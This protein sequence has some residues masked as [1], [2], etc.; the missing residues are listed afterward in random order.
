MTL[1]NSRRRSVM[2]KIGSK[3]GEHIKKDK[4]IVEHT[5]KKT[6]VPERDSES[7]AFGDFNFE[8]VSN[9]GPDRTIDNEGEEEEEYMSAVNDDNEAAFADF[10]EQFAAQ[11]LN[12]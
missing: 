6:N 9:K 12:V 1:K 7:P 5:L 4:I 11:G 3:T 2:I 8:E 10:E